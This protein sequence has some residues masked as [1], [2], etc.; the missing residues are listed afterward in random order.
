MDTWL[1]YIE[2]TNGNRLEVERKVK[3]PDRT[4][5]YKKFM[6]QMEYDFDNKVERVGY[7]RK[8]GKWGLATSFK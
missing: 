6:H 2:Y 3:C 8:N 1:I 7:C 5:E 4:K